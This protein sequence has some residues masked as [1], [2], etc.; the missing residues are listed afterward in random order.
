MNTIE[1]IVRESIREKIKHLFASVR[2]RNIEYVG[3]RFGAQD[4]LF[5]TA[6]VSATT[7]AGDKV[8]APVVV[9]YNPKFSDSIYRHSV[10]VDKLLNCVVG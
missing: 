5:Y 2:I 10:K 4:I 3:G 6:T 9:E 1:N 8:S 7:F